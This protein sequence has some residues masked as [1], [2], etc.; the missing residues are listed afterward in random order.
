MRTSLGIVALLTV[1]IAG[2][3]ACATKGYVSSRIGTVND[4]VETMGKSIEATQERTKANEGKIGVVDGKADA[5]QQ[6]A[7]QAGKAAGA[8]DARAGAVDAKA[9]AL[10]RASKR[11]I[12]TLVLSS[13]EGNFEFGRTTLPAEAKARI[14]ELIAKVKANPQGAYFEIEGYTDNVGP[15][16]FNERLG[17]ERAEE[18][19]RYLYAQHQIPLHRISVISYGVEKPVAPNTTKAGRAQNRRVVIRVVA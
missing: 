12:Y 4:K 18:V 11:I 1:A 9:D 7:N 14:D 19:K 13:E 8:A 16:D 6:A 10:D 15:K 17:L 5:A 2:G 3:S